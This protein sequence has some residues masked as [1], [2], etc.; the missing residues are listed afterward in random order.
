MFSEY[1]ILHNIHLKR[2]WQKENGNVRV[3]VYVSFKKHK[4]RNEEY[5]LTCLKGH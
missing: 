4:K 3:S 5:Y 1:M 2:Q